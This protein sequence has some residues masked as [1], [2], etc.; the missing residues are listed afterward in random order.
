[1]PIYM[2]V[3]TCDALVLTACMCLCKLKYLHKYING[4]VLS[5]L[6]RNELMYIIKV[7]Y[8]NA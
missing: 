6:I 5:R 7:N 1:M 3:C 8:I 4:H 2:A